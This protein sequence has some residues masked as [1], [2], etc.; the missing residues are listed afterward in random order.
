[1]IYNLYNTATHKRTKLE[2]SN[3]M[4]ALAEAKDFLNM[5]ALSANVAYATTSFKIYELTYTNYMIEEEI[6]V[7]INI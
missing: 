5:K 3:F 2:A 7:N 4:Q 6:S 1:M